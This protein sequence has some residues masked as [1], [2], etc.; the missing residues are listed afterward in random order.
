MSGQACVGARFDG[1]R[2]RGEQQRAERFVVVMERRPERRAERRLGVAAERVGQKPRE[3]SWKERESGS[4]LHSDPLTACGKK[5]IRKYLEVTFDSRKGT[6]DDARIASAAMQLPS[7]AIDRLMR[8]A[9]SS[10]RRRLNA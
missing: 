5:C 7:A 6:C 1:H 4:E 2:A 8:F 9:S 10:L 3:L